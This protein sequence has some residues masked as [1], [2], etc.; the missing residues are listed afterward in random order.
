M[1]K[2]FSILFALTLTTTISFSQTQM[3]VTAGV[4]MSTLSGNDL[5]NVMEAFGFEMGSRPG[6]RIGFSASKELSDVLA[7]NSG[8]IY[9]AKGYSFSSSQSDGNAALNYIELP[10][11]LAFSVSDQFSLM[12]GFYSAFLMSVNSILDGEEQ[13][14]DM[15]LFASIDVGIGLGAQFYIND[16]ISIN[17]G[18]QMGIVPLREPIEAIEF[19]DKNANIFIGITYNFGG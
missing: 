1:K 19:D 12:G 6:I 9:S 3:G 7:L 16:D 15:D 13:E 18:Y 10:V 5:S 8:V 14:Q 4:N 11:N 17:A 2:I